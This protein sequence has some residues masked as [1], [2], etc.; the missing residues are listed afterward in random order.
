[1]IKNTLE[2]DKDDLDALLPRFVTD[3]VLLKKLSEFDFDDA[4]LHGK[5]AGIPVD[6]EI[7]VTKAG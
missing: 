1:M 5:Y 6:L 7:R 3:A 2:I 4:V